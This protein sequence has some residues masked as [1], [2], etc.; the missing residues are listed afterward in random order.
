MHACF[1]LSVVAHFLLL[2]S[3]TN[4][5]FLLFVKLRKPGST[6]AHVGWHEAQEV[7]RQSAQYVPVHPRQAEGKEQYKAEGFLHAA[8]HQ[9]G[10]FRVHR[11]RG[12][13]VVERAFWDGQADKRCNGPV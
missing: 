10:A 5:A 12:V 4:H 7:A 13:R 8:A 6:W 9:A 2:R 1:E 3:V 11:A